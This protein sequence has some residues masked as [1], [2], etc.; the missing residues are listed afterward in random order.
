M[1]RDNKLSVVKLSDPNYIRT[2]ENSIQ[3]GTPVLMENVGEELDPS[4][5]SVL[6]KQTFKQAGVICLKLGE[7][8]LEYSEDFRFYITTKLPNPHYL[9]E[10]ATKV[11]LLNFMITPEG[12][13]DQLLGIVV[14]KER[15]EL[16]KERQ[17]LIVQSANNKKQLKEIE[18]RILETL[19][20][21]EGNILED[22][23]AIKVLDEA[24]L[25]SDEISAK[26]KIAEETEKKINESR[27]GYKPVATHSSILFFVIA[28]LANI[29]PM[30]QYSL[31]WFV[32]LYVN[33][34]QDS[35]KSK[36][37]EKRLK[38]LTDHFTYS[39]Y[40]NVCRSLFEKDKLLFSFLLCSALL[41]AKGE[42]DQEEFMFFLTGGVGLE[43]KQPNPDSSWISSKM[44]DEM[45][46]MCDLPSFKGFLD[47]FKENHGQLK[48]L[49]DSKSPQTFE[50]P[51]PWNESFSDFQK[52]I[53]LRVL[54]PDKVV[55]SV[56]LFVETKL[57]KKFTQ[58]PPFDLGQSYNDSHACAPLIFV[59]SPGADPMA[60]LLK[61]AED[62]GF[63]GE[64]F[65]A[66]SLGQGQGPF[67][68]Q[69]IKDGIANG[70]WVVLQNCH[71][72]VSWMS[73]L[74]KICEELKPEDV[75]KDFRLWLTSYPSDKFPVAVLQ[76]GVKMTNEPPTGLRMNLLQSY[77]TDP[78]SDP[79]FYKQ[80]EDQPKKWAAFQKLLFGLCF[81]HAIVQERRK[82]GPL[83]WNIPYGFNESDLRISV[84]QLNIFLG[85]YDEIP[86]DAIHYLT[87]HC[88]YGGRVTDDWDRRCLISILNNAYGPAVV[89]ENKY[90]FSPAGVY[91]VPPP[92]DY[93]TTVAFI[94]ALPV[95]QL[96]EVFGMHDN[97]DISKELQET[98]RLFDS[99]LLTQAKSSSGSSGGGSSDAL[100]NDIASDILSKIPANFDLEDALEK[101]PT[102]YE[103]SMNTVLVQEMQR[104]NALISVIRQSL[105]SLI[106]AIKGLVVMSPDLEDVGRSLLIGKVPELW[107][108]KSYPS[109]KPLGSYVQDLLVRI[110]FLQSWYD[111]GTKPETF[112]ISGF[113][114]TQAFLT[115]ALQNFARK[116]KIPI[117][118]LG[119]DFEVMKD[120]AQRPEDGVLIHGLFLDGAR[121]DP[122]TFV[123]AE[124]L[125]KI[126]FDS[127]PTIWLSPKKKVPCCCR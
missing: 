104:F 89:Q 66:I 122:D 55:Q 18:G 97:V 7:S 116:Y 83:G 51:A 16:E 49:Y 117:D 80:L 101:F 109:L 113:Y 82:F 115:G 19:S 59:L 32:N 50:I 58:P 39:L 26:Q 74:E 91:H 95:E 126:L 119:F 103:E 85:E 110:E 125:P 57:G 127:M 93:D 41:K 96:P 88:N 20:A 60:G 64:K 33:S 38:Y 84:R 47:W 45:C 111:A 108:S 81:F 13:E 86:Y 92:V 2:L 87:G 27:Q 31:G 6:L 67:A 75:H 71:L 15:P 23:S 17:E 77:L 78:V 14:A 9:P 118:I 62:S 99:V 3:F 76:N 106:K 68:E 5:E 28:E 36:V 11:T 124:S 105:Q 54:R 22:E 56:R 42:M 102:R 121:W 52:M 112:W 69:M 1:E 12:L 72:A 37:L 73:S 61:F 65:N 40:C 44:W 63:G 29:D 53:Q 25:L 34:I 8:V 43:N 94:K 10:T 123:L 35:S 98:N 21:S 79:A 90:K 46:R 120:P 107:A 30:Y 4:L 24:K 48:P 100:L 114:F 70:T